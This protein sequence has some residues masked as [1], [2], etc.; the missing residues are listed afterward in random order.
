[1]PAFLTVQPFEDPS[2]HRA[3]ASRDDRNASFVTPKPLENSEVFGPLTR[4]L[5]ETVNTAAAVASAKIADSSAEGFAKQ[6]P[7]VVAPIPA[8]YQPL[9]DA[10][11]ARQR[12]Q[13]GKRADLLAH[14]PAIPHGASEG[15]KLRLTFSHNIQTA[16]TVAMLTPMKPSDLINAASGN[17]ELGLVILSNPSLRAKLPGD[18]VERLESDTMELAWADLL[19]NGVKLKPTYENPLLQGNDLAAAKATARQAV[20][21][22]QAAD[23]EIA[24][25]EMVL[26]S[27]VDFVAIVGD[28]SRADA[29]GILNG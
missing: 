23:D 28:V 17:R 4:R 26:R 27:A 6:F 14:A 2:T 15:E 19:A 25:V 10:A 12:E 9:R 7:A 16:Q 22:M 20:A 11:M 18:L 21:A 3:T 8:A 24:S 5:R 29:F 1:M 13:D